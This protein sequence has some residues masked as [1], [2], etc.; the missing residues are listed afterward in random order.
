MTADD[1]GVKNFK[2]RSGNTFRK[3]FMW[4]EPGARKISDLAIT[5]G[6]TVA[7]SETAVFTA[8]DDDTKLVV[9]DGV[10]VDDGTTITYVSPTEVALSEPATATRNNVKAV[11]RGMNASAYTGHRAHFK[12]K[13]GPGDPVA[14]FDVDTSRAAVGVFVISMS[15][16]VT[17]TLG[18]SGVWDWE[19][20]GPDGVST[21]VEGKVTYVKDATN[22][23]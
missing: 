7:T 3:T 8:D 23:E 15:A 1:P 22:D 6:S 16:S 5:S 14:V 18:K 2:V 17:E 13:W 20:T 19:V 11:V 21:W 10:G 4:G 12:Y 9:Q